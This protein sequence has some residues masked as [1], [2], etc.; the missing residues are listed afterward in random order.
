ML[1]E[2]NRKGFM[3]VISSPSGGGKTTICQA[4]LD[5]GAPFEF[6]VSA[7][8]RPP[9][10]DEIDG[11]SY[12][13]ISDDEFSK[14][15]EHDEFAEW[16]A[17]HGHRYGTPK[18]FVER[19]LETGKIMIFEIDVQGAMKLKT[20]YPDDTAS[21]FIM[22][23]SLDEI[24]K[25]LGKRGTNSEADIRLRLKNARAEIARAKEFDYIVINNRI[26]NAIEDTLAIAKTEMLAAHR[27]NDLNGFNGFGI[28]ILPSK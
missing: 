12:H 14:M 17:V 4:L 18:R 28:T 9:R 27:F 3:L 2:T 22:P 6:S 1:N 11:V 23:P 24:K 20:A 8:T 26:E 13:F 7:T 15:I 10:P 5:M 21:I 25:R 19:A 16:A